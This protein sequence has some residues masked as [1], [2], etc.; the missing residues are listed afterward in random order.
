M[1]VVCTEC[2]EIHQIHQIE[3]AICKRC[4]RIMSP[5]ERDILAAVAAKNG[6][7]KISKNGSMGL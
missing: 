1:D 5:Y 7:G 2:N 6:K 4:Q 3:N